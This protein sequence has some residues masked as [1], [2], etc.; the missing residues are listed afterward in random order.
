MNSGTITSGDNVSFWID[1][2]PILS[3][4]T[5]DQDITT[6]VLVIGGGIAGSFYSVL[7]LFGKAERR[8]KKVC[9]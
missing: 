4:N 1:S 5:P 7:W 9:R 3:Y 2:S 8:R 6:E